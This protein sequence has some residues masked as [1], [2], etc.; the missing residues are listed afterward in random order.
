MTPSSW[1][2]KEF[3]SSTSLNIDWHQTTH[4]RHIFLASPAGQSPDFPVVDAM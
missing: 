4:T 2:R 3:I 1:R